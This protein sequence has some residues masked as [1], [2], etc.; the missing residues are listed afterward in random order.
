VELKAE[1][2]A[3]GNGHEKLLFIEKHLTNNRPLLISLSLEPLGIPNWHTVPAVD[4]DATTVTLLRAMRPD[5]T[6]QLEKINK[7]ML[8]QIHDN[9][10]GGDD[11]AYLVRC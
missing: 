8:V 7:C 3:Q 2:W 9:F 1:A 11:V 10:K 6:H 4:M 5:G